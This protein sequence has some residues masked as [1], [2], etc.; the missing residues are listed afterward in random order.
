M[1]YDNDEDS[2]QLGGRPN[3]LKNN[4][5]SLNALQV[6]PSRTITTEIVIPQRLT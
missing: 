1:V 4:R 6:V 2:E 5:A 3:C